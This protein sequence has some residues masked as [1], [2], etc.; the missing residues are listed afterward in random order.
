MNVAYINPFL[1][2]TTSVFKTMVKV[3]VLLGKPSL[4]D[5][6]QRL[7][8]VFPLS[9]VIALSG[10]ASGV[11]VMC[12]TGQVA[13][14][15]ASAFAGKAIAKMDDE[16]RDALGEIANMIAGGAKKNLLGS[17]TTISTPRLMDTAEVEYPK[18]GPVISVPVDTGVG[19]FMIEVSLKE[20][21]SE[22][23]PSSDAAAPRALT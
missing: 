23:G 15:M 14:A 8:K 13:L 3:P 9:A 5:E 7:H 2:A 22:T 12:L 20:G 1:A 21:S 19:R 4:R 16:V 18:N 10:A 17:L 11:V 6:S